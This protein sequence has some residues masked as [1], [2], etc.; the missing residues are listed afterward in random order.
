MNDNEI[1]KIINGIRHRLDRNV[2]IEN[3]RS[4]RAR[5]MKE[6]PTAKVK[7]SYK[8][9]QFTI[10]YPMSKDYFKILSINSS[11]DK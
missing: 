4:Q 1:Y 2:F 10:L 3:W 9:K 6:H 11:I 5:L 7:Y 8:T